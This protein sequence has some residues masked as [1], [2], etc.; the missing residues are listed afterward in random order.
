VVVF[1]ACGAIRAA[2]REG[3]AAVT[4]LGPED[5]VFFGLDTSLQAERVNLKDEIGSRDMK[6]DERRV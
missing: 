5:V 2:L 3:P 6:L 4:S 1:G